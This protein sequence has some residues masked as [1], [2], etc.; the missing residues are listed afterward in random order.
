MEEGG[1]GAAA[2]ALEILSS[3]AVAAAQGEAGCIAHGVDAGHARPSSHGAGALM[4]GDGGRTALHEYP[5]VWEQARF[6][7]EAWKQDLSCD[8]EKDSDLRGLFDAFNRLFVTCGTRR[9]QQ[10]HGSTCRQ[11]QEQCGFNDKTHPV[12]LLQVRGVG[13]QDGAAQG[14]NPSL[15]KAV[16]NLVCAALGNCNC[17]ERRGRSGGDQWLHYVKS[18]ATACKSVGVVDSAEKRGRLAKI[19]DDW[20]TPICDALVKRMHQYRDDHGLERDGVVKMYLLLN[21]GVDYGLT[22]AGARVI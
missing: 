18:I 7:P 10:G 1:E 16:N 9:T 20:G 12:G 6:R 4:A 21:A 5:R 3:V 11:W 17:V 15:F 22:F 19:N 13:A 2:M 14:A 8:V